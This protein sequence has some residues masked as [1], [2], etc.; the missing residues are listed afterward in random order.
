MSRIE[1]AQLPSIL[2]ILGE[3]PSDDM[4]SLQTIST[5]RK[6]WI[7]LERYDVSRDLLLSYAEKVVQWFSREWNGHFLA[8]AYLQTID[9]ST[10]GPSSSLGIP[11]LDIV[12][13]LTLSSDVD[14]GEQSKQIMESWV[15]LSGY[16]GS[17]YRTIFLLKLNVYPASDADADFWYFCQSFVIP[18]I[19]LTIRLLISSQPKDV[20]RVHDFCLKLYH[21]F[22]LE[23]DRPL[24]VDA[25][26]SLWKE[27]YEEINCDKPGE[28]HQLLESLSRQATDIMR[29]HREVFVHALEQPKL[30]DGRTSR[31][32]CSIVVALFA[33]EEQDQV[34]DLIDRLLFTPTESRFDG[35]TA[36]GIILATEMLRSQKCNGDQKTKLK[37]RVLTVLLPAN[38]RTVLPDLGIPGLAFLEMCEKQSASVF[39]DVQMI[40]AN[41]GLIQR[42]SAYQQSKRKYVPILGYTSTQQQESDQPSFIFC[43]A[44]FLRNLDCKDFGQWESTVRWVFDLVDVY[45][46]HG[47]KSRKTPWNPRGWLQAVVE[48]PGFEFPFQARGSQQKMGM[49]F[50]DD[51]RTFDINLLDSISAPSSFRTVFADMLLREPQEIPRIYSALLRFGLGLFVGLG[52]S[53]AVLKNAFAYYRALQDVTMKPVVLQMIERQIMK[54]YRLKDKIAAF[55]SVI[56]PFEGVAKKLEN[57]K[58]AVKVGK[59]PREGMPT[60]EGIGQLRDLFSTLN[61]E[62]FCTS[63]FIDDVIL[64]ECLTDSRS[65]DI[66]RSHVKRSVETE[67]IGA[68]DDDV[69]KTLESKSRAVWQLVC[70]GGSSA[71]NLYEHL[72]QLSSLIYFLVPMLPNLRKAL[73]D[74][75]RPSLSA[76]VQFT[77]TSAQLLTLCLRQQVEKTNS[78]ETLVTILSPSLSIAGEEGQSNDVES[79]VK[80]LEQLLCTVDDVYIASTLLDLLAIFGNAE[81]SILE[82]VVTAGDIAIRRSFA[83]PCLTTRIEILPYSVS[84]LSR[85]LKAPARAIEL[86]REALDSTVC[87]RSAGRGR[88]TDTSVI[89]YWAYRYPLL[90]QFGLLVRDRSSSVGI[91]SFQNELSIEIESVLD[92][93]DRKSGSSKKARGS[94]DSGIPEV[95]RPKN[96]QSTIR[97]L[98]DTTFS[99]FYETSLHIS[100]GII[101]LYPPASK[102]VAPLSPYRRLETFL[103]SFHRLVHIYATYYRHFPRRMVSILY[104]SART[105]FDLIEVQINRCVDWRSSC[106]LPQADATYDPGS[107]VYLERLVKSCRKLIVGSLSKVVKRWN[108]DSIQQTKT[109]GKA[110]EQWMG[111]FI[112]NIDDI[113]SA[114]GLSSED[115]DLQAATSQTP[116]ANKKRRMGTISSN[117][118]EEQS[119]SSSEG[120]IEDMDEDYISEDADEDEEDME[121]D[122]HD[123]FDEEE[124]EDEGSYDEE[125]EEESAV[126]SDDAISIQRIPV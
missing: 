17:L 105:L 16:F 121:E 119:Q 99:D 69:A 94:S 78:V 33:E 71:V 60:T 22:L 51:F 7:Q 109:K 49:K 25:V 123:N 107:L 55:E 46:A 36:S 91:E 4:E 120:G 112:Q 117:Q 79:I 11:T 97:G 124:E 1:K 41:T 84:L 93:M 113:C 76:W 115:D 122:E 104:S 106:Q 57:E 63:K 18:L 5:V 12:V 20:S 13:L 87:R 59:T 101:A 89:S 54:I 61:D 88:W 108:A 96:Y 70:T 42:I 38:R 34:M 10:D 95:R 21:H 58:K 26:I 92:C 3:F 56:A 64:W 75:S 8:T 74:K 15:E 68:D 23:S 47:R 29:W 39:R 72:Q 19:N 40:L 2:E 30:T 53:A 82:T 24:F 80:G 28:I 86:I 32:I 27:K 118:G 81:T 9:E 45:L 6:L 90:H 48:F 125:D 114:H 66:I 35:R 98:V 65:N 100:V 111:R 103:R 83:K 62:I 37:S 52:L 73:H 50:L 102:Q 14:F 126:D 116:S 44:F 85:S 110:L 43:A 77:A 67:T 31:S